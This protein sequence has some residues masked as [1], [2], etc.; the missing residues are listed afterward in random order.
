MANKWTKMLIEDIPVMG[1]QPGSLDSLS[2]QLE[3][4]RRQTMAQIKA[5][6]YMLWSV[7]A[8]TITSGLNAIFAFLAWYAPHSH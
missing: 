8:I 6:K 1:G 5:A 7:V 2:A 3:L 4:A